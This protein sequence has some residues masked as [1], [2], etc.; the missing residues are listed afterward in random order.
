[1]SQYTL[2]D[3]QET[4]VA[5]GIKNSYA[6]FALKMGQGKSFCALT[7]A[8]RTKSK[9]LI[10]C[11][12]YLKLKWQAEI[13]KFYPGTVS[14]IFNNDKEFYF[15][16]DSEFVIISS[17]FIEKA[18]K[19]FEWADLVVADESHIYKT[20][21]SRRCEALHKHVFENSIKRLLLLTGTPI[22]NRVYEFYSLIALCQYNPSLEESAFLKAYPSYVDFAN[23]FSNLR[24]FSI[25]T[26]RGSKIVQQW[27]GYKNEGE[28]KGWLKDIYI[29]FDLEE[30]PF[31]EIF[32]PVDYSD[33]PE[34]LEAFE[35]FSADGENKSVMSTVKAKAALA[36]APF[37]VE[38]VKNLLEQDSQVVVYSDHPETAKFI[39]D[40]IGLCTSIDG[41]TAMHLRQAQADKFQSGAQ[42]IIVATIGSFSTGIDLFS[43]YN[44]VFSDPNWVPGNMDQAKARISRLGQTKE[45][46]FHYIIGSIQDEI[47]LDRLDKKR[48][49][50]R[51]II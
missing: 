7:V 32:I 36:K 46:I 13:N 22:Q 9:T 17:S 24:E 20:M 16:W 27:E 35:T 28:L 14:S 21:S 12:S 2:K 51:A 25:N 38:Y 3:Y 37:T 31:K 11:P 42:K 40:K 39:A 18:E 10:I 49:T 44:M 29:R 45:C 48:E 4:T 33:D 50:I 8:K 47:I 19:L 6:I 30:M 1:M 43:S 34:L 23:R 5:F 26:K 15:P 41:T